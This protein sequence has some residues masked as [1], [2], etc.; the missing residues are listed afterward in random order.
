MAAR[1]GASDSLRILEALVCAQ[2]GMTVEELS[3][4]LGMAWHRTNHRV[5][6]MAREGFLEVAGA[7][8]RR[9]SRGL[10]PDLFRVGPRLRS[11]AMDAAEKWRAEIVGRE[12]PGG[13]PA[14][15]RV[16]W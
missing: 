16:Q 10:A 9:R 13:V 1:K 15:P 7:G 6:L 11:A 5:R 2:A 12:I 4:A 3:E 14:K 8:R